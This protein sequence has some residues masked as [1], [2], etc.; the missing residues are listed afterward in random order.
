MEGGAK[1]REK[2]IEFESLDFEIVVVGTGPK[3]GAVG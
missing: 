1:R 3:I 2:G